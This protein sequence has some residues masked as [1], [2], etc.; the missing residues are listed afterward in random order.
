MFN[1]DYQYTKYNFENI[2]QV[3]N[4]MLGWTELG[5]GDLE[6]TIDDYRLTGQ[7]GMLLQNM[8]HTYK[9]QNIIEKVSSP[10]S[11]SYNVLLNKI[12]L[13]LNHPELAF[14]ILNIKDET[15]NTISTVGVAQMNSHQLAHAQALYIK[16]NDRYIDYPPEILEALGLNPNLSNGALTGAE[17]VGSNVPGA[18]AY[19]DDE[20]NHYATI[21]DAADNSVI[22]NYGIIDTTSQQTQTSY[23][24]TRLPSGEIQT[25]QSTNT[26]Y[27]VIAGTETQAG[28]DA[29]LE[30]Q[31]NN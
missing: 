23:T 8:Y 2:Q 20:V 26:S 29:Y 22:N 10:N 17:D 1:D 28:Q 15:G 30:S 16:N 3:Y 11:G 25:T 6:N 31:G 9:N 7:D 21:I 27:G 12:R 24:Q 18:Q 4:D 5:E 14:N 13:A 19:T